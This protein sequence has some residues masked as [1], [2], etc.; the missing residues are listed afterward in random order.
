MAKVEF[1]TENMFVAMYNKSLLVIFKSILKLTNEA[2]F[3]PIKI[4]CKL[5]KFNRG[6]ESCSI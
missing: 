6:F 2:L 1:T 4:A 3:V 5:P